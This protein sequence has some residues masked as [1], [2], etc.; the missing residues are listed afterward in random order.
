MT[1]QMRENK[2]LTHLINYFFRFILKIL[3][4][5]KLFCSGYDKVGLL[6]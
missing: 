6:R 3:D 1:I 4:E 5:I 2:D